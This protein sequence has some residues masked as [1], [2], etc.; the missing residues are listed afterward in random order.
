MKRI[1]TI[2][3]FNI[4]TLT[5]LAQFTPPPTLSK[6][7][8]D[9]VHGFYLTDE[10]RW[11]E[12]KK[13]EEVV[14]WTRTQHDATI[15]YM[16]KH[17]PPIK[18]L[19]DEI[20]AYI[21][22]DI[23][24]PIRLVADRQFYYK[25]TK[26]EAQYKMYTRIDNKDLLVFDPM[27]IDTS[28]E[29][30]ISGL[31]Y[32]QTADTIAVGLQT[33]GAEISTFYIVNSRTGEILGDPIEGLRGFGFT[34]DGQHAYIT[35]G[36]KEILE[37][38]IPLK[39]YLHKIG[40]NRK[41][42]KFLL[43]PATAKDYVS[44]SDARYSD[45]TFIT[46]GNFQ[47][48]SIKIRKAGTM[49][50]PI[51]IYT[52][53]EFRAYPFALDDKIYFFTNHE[54][55]NYKIMIA[56]KSKPQFE[57]WEEIYGEKETVLENFVVTNKYLIIQDRKDVLSRI[58]ICD[59]DG[60]FIRQLELPE[61]GNVSYI[62]YHRPSNTLFVSLST[63]TAPAKLYKLDAT[64][65]D[66][67]EFFY[68][69]DVPVDTKEIEAKIDFYLSKDGSKVPLFIVHKKGIVL[70]GNNPTLLSGY[71]G[72][73]FGI[74]P[75]FVGLTASFINR[76]GVYV[77]AGIRG[78]DE[79][80]EDWHKDGM[81]HNKQNCFDDFIA[82]AEYIIDQKYTSSEKLVIYGGS[83][84][85]L[86]MGAMVTQ[87]PD[88]FKAVVCGVPLLDM[89]RFHKFLI[90][91]Y[92]IPEYGDPDKREDF[93]NILQYSPYH[94]IRRGIN[95]PTMMVKAGENDTRVDPLHAKKFVAA[96]QNNPGQLSPIMLYMDYD[97]GH[98]SGKSTEQLVY[99]LQVHW[100]F[101][102]NQLGMK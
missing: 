1:F 20:V 70:D 91:K 43:A 41:E 65:L 57:H 22:R 24:G 69:S 78:G 26:G 34:K 28:G 96:L 64:E 87:R 36:T 63:F 13:N 51:E 95:H 40:S 66:E 94:N 31:S 67:W 84:G 39:T 76:G 99:D 75:R 15:A 19:E 4:I 11:L 42:D 44:F 68:Q 8:V 88:L 21:D 6:P 50:T 73:N 27:S 53:K 55:S 60:K 30:A 86:L 56:N 49:D 93:Q 90:A 82:A 101:I 102:M 45:C 16:E 18:G 2:L 37:K 52:S 58:L 12:D 85:G 46:E 83:N 5:S 33:K 80:G 62:N 89:V 17:C 10:Y 97:S 77:R 79:Y 25:K 48:N 100:G 23:E 54:A 59:L 35:A 72:F 9:T 32:T 92:W 98:G 81:M 14:K 38:Q 7:V 74:T 47:A 61:L 29:S 3:A 71:G